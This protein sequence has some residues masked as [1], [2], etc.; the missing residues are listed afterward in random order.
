MLAKDG[1]TTRSMDA[2]T[3]RI[4]GDATHLVISTG[5][6]DA[7]GHIDLLDAPITS[8]ADALYAFDE[9]VTAFETDYRLAVEPVFAR[10]LQ[11]TVCTIYNGAFEDPRLARRARI[12][13]RR[14]TM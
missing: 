6:N 1:A 12:A 7:L 9:C 11:A 10:G 5:G 2:Q 14:P 8:T 13:L 4:P 3:A